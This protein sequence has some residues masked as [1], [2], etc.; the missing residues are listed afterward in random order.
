MLGDPSA[1]FVRGYPGPVR[2]VAGL[3]SLQFRH[4]CQ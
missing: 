2:Y 1:Q 3:K 4:D